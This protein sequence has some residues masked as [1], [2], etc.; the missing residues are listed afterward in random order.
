[1]ALSFC[2]AA[3]RSSTAAIN[4]CHW[5]YVGKRGAAFRRSCVRSRR[6]CG[7]HNSAVAGGHEN[8]VDSATAT[9][10]EPVVGCP[11][12]GAASDVDLARFDFRII[13]AMQSSGRPR[14]DR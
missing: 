6:L 12:N 7:A 13:R 2:E 8:A 4:D 10:G 11:S 14:Q 3:A 9:V 1:M 5:S